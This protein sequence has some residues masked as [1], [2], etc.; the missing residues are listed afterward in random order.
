MTVLARASAPG[1]LFLTGE[2]AVLLGGCAVGMAV[3]RRAIAE[4]STGTGRWNTLSVSGFTSDAQAFRL[5]ADGNIHWQN[6][7]AAND[8]KL[9]TTV[10]SLP[11]F[12]ARLHALQPF[13]LTLDTSGFFEAGRKLGLGSSAALSVALTRAISR[14]QT[15]N[16]PP[17]MR[18]LPIRQ[19]SPVAAAG[20]M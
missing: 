6:P 20:S 10:I 11:H 3:E 18:W 9:V 16:F 5:S 15:W 7:A 1:K 13:C 8:Y 17:P 19:Y 12:H 2:Y 4:L 14:R